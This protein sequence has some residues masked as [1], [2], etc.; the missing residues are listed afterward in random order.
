MQIQKNALRSA[1]SLIVNHESSNSFQGF[2]IGSCSNDLLFVDRFDIGRENQPTLL[3]PRDISIPICISH[4]KCEKLEKS[5]KLPHFMYL[6]L[7][8]KL[9]SWMNSDPSFD[10]NLFSFVLGIDKSQIQG[11]LDCISACRI[12]PNILFKLNQIPS[13]KMIPNRLYEDILFKSK[14]ETSLESIQFGFMTM[15]QARHLLLLSCN[16][17]Q[18]LSLSMIGIWVSGMDYNPSQTEFS[19]EFQT[20]S[21]LRELLCLYILNSKIRKM[22]IGK[23]QFLLN[24]FESK[25]QNFVLYQVEYDYKD[26]KPL[27]LTCRLPLDQDSQFTMLSFESTEFSLGFCDAYEDV[28]GM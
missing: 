10:V 21:L 19:Q 20:D 2:F 1:M 22:D 28:F 9:Q 13:I 15:D 3:I 18:L 24:I 17:S 14:S 5:E 26:N 23:P 25:I 27:L 4:E 6:Y 7:L 12:L 8:K 16:D 11:E